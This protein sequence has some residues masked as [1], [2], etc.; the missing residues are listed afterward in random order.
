MQKT[1]GTPKPCIKVLNSISIKAFFIQSQS[2]SQS[3]FFHDVK[4]FEY[5]TKYFRDCIITTE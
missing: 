5:S 1:L 3:K 4:I 2:D